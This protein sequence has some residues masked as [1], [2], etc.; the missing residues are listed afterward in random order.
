MCVHKKT[1]VRY[2]VKIINVTDLLKT[3]DGHFT[4]GRIR[5]EVAILMHLAGHP[6]IVL[7]KDVYET[8]DEIYLV[9]ELC[10]G[11]S[12]IDYLI[13][14]APLSEARAASIFHQ[15]IKSVLHCHEVRAPGGRR[16]SVGFGR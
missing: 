3:E 9:Q 16:G 13:K 12:L 8:A 14:N 6:N 2:A 5:S 1:Q 10:S 7:L 11:G 15:I 4:V